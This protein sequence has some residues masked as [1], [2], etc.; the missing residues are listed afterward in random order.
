MV[1]ISALVARCVPSSARA[2]RSFPRQCPAL[3]DPSG[4]NEPP[5]LHRTLFWKTP[6]PRLQMAA[7]KRPTAF[8]LATAARTMGSEMSLWLGWLPAYQ[9]SPGSSLRPPRASGSPLGWLPAPGSGVARIIWNA[10]V[11]SADSPRP[12]SSVW[13]LHWRLPLSVINCD[14]HYREACRPHTKHSFPDMECMC[15]V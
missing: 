5:S 14:V 7:F 3:L 8:K 10:P 13:P 1:V 9:R 11:D 6:S 15:A 2:G 12:C 4:C